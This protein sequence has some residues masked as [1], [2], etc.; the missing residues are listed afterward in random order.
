MKIS[1]HLGYLRSRKMVS[2][3]R[4]QNWIIYSLPKP[5][6]A[7]LERN[8]K[9]LHDCIHTHPVFRRDLKKLFT[10]RKRCCEPTRLF[11]G[12]A[13]SKEKT[14]QNK[15]FCSFAFITAHAARWRP[16]CLT[17]HAANFSTRRAPAWNQARST[18]LSPRHFRNSGSTSRKARRN[19]VRRLEVGANLSICNHRLQRS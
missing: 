4:E 2:T 1:K 6:A 13:N 16:R 11:D 19:A 14:C 5:A 9:C 8:L 17:R 10:L 7:E 15:E 3:D 18:R 12:A